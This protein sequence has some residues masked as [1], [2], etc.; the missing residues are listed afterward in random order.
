MALVGGER[1]S[2]VVGA[3]EISETCFGYFEAT[4]YEK[5]LRSKSLLPPRRSGF[6]RQRR[7]AEAKRRLTP[8]G[9]TKKIQEDPE[10]VLF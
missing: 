4:P 9:I 1:S 10:R 6:A 5:D 8:A 2:L 7:I 3:E